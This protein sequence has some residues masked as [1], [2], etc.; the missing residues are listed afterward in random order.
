MKK[1]KRK[2]K[3]MFNKIK[4]SMSYFK[5]QLWYLKEFIS[6]FDVKEAVQTTS[7]ILKGVILG[8]S[9]LIAMIMCSLIAQNAHDAYL[10]NKVSDKVVYMRSPEDA[11]RQGSG[12][13]FHMRTPSGKVVIVTNA[14][15]CGL[16]NKNGEIM[17]EEKV[18]SQRLIKRHVLE[19]FEKNDLCV[20]EPLPGYDGLEMA[21]DVSPSQKVWTFGY[22]LG[23]GLNISKGRIKEF[24]TIYLMAEG[25]PLN[26]C[27]GPRLKKQ[28]AIVFIFIIEMCMKAHESISTDVPT[29]PGNSG[30]PMLDKYG[31]VVGVIFA[32][33]SYTH[34]GHAVP[35]KDLQ[36]LM[37]AY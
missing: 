10:E 7:N 15:I 30:S 26:K 4:D 21:K 8:T 9:L 33:N 20:V 28:Q 13:G 32:S 18:H 35:L 12:T 5:D 2:L 25:I 24:T 29:Y 23:E 37:S 14:H 17:V 31:N 3:K 27:E 16:A 34:W 36:D 19:V 11:E 22:P 6:E 1:A